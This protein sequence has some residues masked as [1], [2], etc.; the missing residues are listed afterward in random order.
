LSLKR[1]FSTGL[2]SAAVAKLDRPGAVHEFAI[3]KDV[4]LRWE[5]EGKVRRLR[6]FDAT[7]GAVNEELRFSPQVADEL[8]KYRVVK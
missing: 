1:E 7:T 4:L 2:D 6:D 8:I 3:P 5:M